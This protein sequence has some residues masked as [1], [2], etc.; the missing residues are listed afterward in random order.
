MPDS[1]IKPNA[2]ADLFTSADLEDRLFLESE[3]SGEFTAERLFRKRPDIYRAIIILL[4]ENRGQISIGR[5]LSVSPSTVRAVAR[6]E[7]IQIGIEKQRLADK[8]F[9]VAHLAIELLQEILADPKRRAEL[10]GKELAAIADVMAGKGL[11]LAGEATARVDVGIAPAPEHEDFNAYVERLRSAN[12]AEMGL[13]GEK[14]G[15]EKSAAT[16]ATASEACAMGAP[17]AERPALAAPS[18]RDPILAQLDQ[19]QGSVAV[20]LTSNQKLSSGN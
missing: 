7:G 17:G 20:P 11:L 3:Q 13:G 2:Q 1:L 14:S 18:G 5:L 6:R 19:V 16:S 4:G 12:P 10:S 9:D 15:G 8:A